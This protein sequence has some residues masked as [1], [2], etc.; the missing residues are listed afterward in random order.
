MQKIATFVIEDILK[1]DINN[2]DTTI[3]Y[4]NDLFGSKSAQKKL[5]E[6]AGADS[7]FFKRFNIW[8]NQEDFFF[9]R[10]K[11]IDVTAFINQYWLNIQDE[12]LLKYKKTCFLYLSEVSLL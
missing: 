5:S 9:G 8:L 10:E 11:L 7:G 2:F 6:I 3:W 1:Q 4:T 12:Q